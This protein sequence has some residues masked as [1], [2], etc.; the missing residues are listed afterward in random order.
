MEAPTAALAESA[1]ASPVE[2]PGG[3]PAREGPRRFTIRKMSADKGYLSAENVETISYYGGQAFIAPKVTTTGGI[4]GLFEK[5]FYYYQYRRDE[6]MAHC[7][8]RSN[9]E[10]VFSAVKRKLGDNVRARRRDGQ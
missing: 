8:K 3:T 1:T 2:V 10:S 4:C 7:H 5:M 9:V 6:F